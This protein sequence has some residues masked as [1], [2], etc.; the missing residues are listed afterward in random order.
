[1]KKK[2]ENRREEKVAQ[3]P[4][5]HRLAWAVM[6][7]GAATAVYR[8]RCRQ[9]RLDRHASLQLAE[10]SLLNQLMLINK[11]SHELDPGNRLL[12]VC[13]CVCAWK[14]AQDCHHLATKKTEKKPE[15]CR[16]HLSTG[17]QRKQM[18]WRFKS[19]LKGFCS[20]FLLPLL[21][22]K[23]TRKYG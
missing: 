11:N 6:K 12:C 19:W 22:C 1:M 8:Y 2:N 4:F 17:E 20:P 3:E 23:A 5:K 10:V 21:P 14:E 18:N 9:N 13:V 7:W 15:N 16:L